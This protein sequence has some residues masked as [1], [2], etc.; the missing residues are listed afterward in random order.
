MCS[1]AGWTSERRKRKPINRLTCDDADFVDG[2][3]P[4]VDQLQQ[5]QFKHREIAGFSNH[6]FAVCGRV[7]DLRSCLRFLQPALPVS[8]DV[9]GQTSLPA[10]GHGVRRKFCCGQSA[11]EHRPLVTACG[12]NGVQALATVVHSQSCASVSVTPWWEDLTVLHQ[13]REPE[14]NP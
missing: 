8:I 5:L 1:S 3:F 14:T 10:P 2:F 7:Q 11:G 4:G 13:G 12:H 6:Q 9:D